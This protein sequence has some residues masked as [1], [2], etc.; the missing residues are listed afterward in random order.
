[1]AHTP[2]AQILLEPYRNAVTVGKLRLKEQVFNRRFYYV[3]LQL[4]LLGIPL[5]RGGETLPF[6]IAKPP[7]PLRMF[8]GIPL[9]KM[10]LGIVKNGA[11]GAN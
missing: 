4:V 3:R 6:A 11:V 7:F 10:G 1:M 5:Q 8:L 2:A 9:H